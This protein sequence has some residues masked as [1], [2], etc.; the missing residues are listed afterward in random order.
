M[1][2]GIELAVQNQ[3]VLGFRD[4]PQHEILELLLPAAELHADPQRRALRLRLHDPRQ[5]DRRAQL[6][7]IGVGEVDPGELEHGRDRHVAAAAQGHDEEHERRGDADPT[8][9]VKFSFD[10]YLLS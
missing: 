2:I 3:H 1:G 5:L 9:H 10:Y 6:R 7:R 4:L 8:T